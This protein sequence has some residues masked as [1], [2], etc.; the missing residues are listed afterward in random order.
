MCL[1]RD[2]LLLKII[3]KLWVDGDVCI[4]DLLNEIELIRG[5]GLYLEL[6]IR[7]LDLLLFNLSLFVD[8]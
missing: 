4:M 7:S 3:F 2:D 1:L 8:I 5:L 6:I